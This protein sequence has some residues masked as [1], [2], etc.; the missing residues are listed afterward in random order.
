MDP[1]ISKLQRFA[2]RTIKRTLIKKALY[3]PRSIKA[4]NRAK[5]NKSIDDFGLVEPFVWNKRTGNLVGGHRRL[6]KIDA[7]EGS[8]QYLISVAEIDVDPK[9]EKAL[10]V[11][12]NNHA[13]QGEFDD[14][15]LAKLLA[16]LEDQI[17]LTGFNATD[18]ERMAADAA[19]E[20]QFPITAKLNERHDYVLIFTDN[21]TDFAF[22]QSLCGVEIE[23]SY[24]KTGIG[25]GRAVPF[26]RFLKS[27]RENHHSINVQSGHDDDAPAT[28][29]RANLRPAK[30]AS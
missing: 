18:L 2:T 23:R 5:L 12:L 16:E 14:K 29:E 27:I 19:T 21:E 28:P 17:D 11:I 7:E 8:D 24:K 26:K 6:E 4:G 1:K 15:L 22:L 20:A 13:A 3:N 9:R 10:N 30:S 25:L